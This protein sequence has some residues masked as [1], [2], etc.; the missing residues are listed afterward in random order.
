MA[1]RLTARDMESYGTT[2][3]LAE[4]V[5]TVAVILRRVTISTTGIRQ[6]AFTAMQ[7]AIAVQLQNALHPLPIAQEA[8]ARTAIPA[9]P[10]TAATELPA[11]PL[12]QQAQRAILSGV[13]PAQACAQQASAM[14]L[15]GEGQAVIQESPVELLGGLP[16]CL[17][18]RQL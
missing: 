8:P 13:A 3:S 17:M 14:L 15:L 10:S 18:H 2:Q 16:A 6:R 4:A 5:A 1:S 7:G 11:P 9:M 12:G